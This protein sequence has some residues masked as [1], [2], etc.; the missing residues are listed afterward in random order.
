MDTVWCRLLRNLSL[1]IDDNLI[2]TRHR[3]K[4]RTA[5]GI[6]GRGTWALANIFFLALLPVAQSF[7]PG[8][9][10]K[11]V[12]L[13]YLFSGAFGFFIMLKVRRQPVRN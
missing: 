11:F 4:P 13:G 2:E 12:P 9:I 1:R 6:Y 7:G 3:A 5:N 8:V 10:L